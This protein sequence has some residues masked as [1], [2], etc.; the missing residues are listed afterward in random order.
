MNNTREFNA[1][2]NAFFKDHI[3]KKTRKIK[4]KMDEKLMMYLI[5][6]SPNKMGIY[7]PGIDISKRK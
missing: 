6:H 2:E 4:R 7:C 3:K 1:S 5:R